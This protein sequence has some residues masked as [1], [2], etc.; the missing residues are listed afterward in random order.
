MFGRM[1][2]GLFMPYAVESAEASKLLSQFNGHFEQKLFIL[3]DEAFF[4]GSNEQRRLLKGLITDEHIIYENK[5]KDARAGKNRLRIIMTTNEVW[6]VPA[7]HDDRRFVVLDIAPRQ[8]DDHAYFARLSKECSDPEA[9]AALY[10]YLKSME[11]GEWHPAMMECKTE[12][13]IEQKIECLTPVERFLFESLEEG[14]IYLNDGRFLVWEE[15]ESLILD[16]ENKQ[17]VVKIINSRVDSRNR[18]SDTHVTRTMN[19]IFG[20]INYKDKKGRGW[21]LPPLE[22]ARNLFEKYTGIP[23]RA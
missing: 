14:G 3:A 10:Q 16:R 4:A 9:L 11:L 19:K 7:E 23:V 8:P 6:A 15:E 12:A 5:G 17:E 20:D 1:I 18:V 21:K 13:L 2:M 22:Q